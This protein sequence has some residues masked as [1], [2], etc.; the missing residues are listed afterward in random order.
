MIAVGSDDYAAELRESSL[1]GRLGDWTRTLTKA[2]VVACESIGW[3]AAAKGHRLAEMPESGEEFLGI[4]VM[5]FEEN[6]GL[7]LFPI[8]AVELENSRNDD[9]IAYSLWK[10]LNVQARLRAVL[11]YR[12]SAEDGA[13]LVR[14]LGKTVVQSMSLA[15]RTALDGET[16]IAVGYRNQAE[17]FPYGYFKWWRLNANVGNFELL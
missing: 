13:G 10:V 8:A 2:A 16:V 6:Q 1:E 3:L 17:T 15:D 12:P 7:W 5:A 14:Y 4:D 11:C 9:R